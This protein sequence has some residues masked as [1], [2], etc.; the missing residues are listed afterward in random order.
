MEMGALE[1]VLKGS[2][3]GTL[4]APTSM[5][6]S[7]APSSSDIPPGSPVKAKSVLKKDNANWEE[8]LNKRR[9]YV[10]NRTYRIAHISTLQCPPW[11]EIPKGVGN[12]RVK[13]AG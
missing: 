12:E 1:Q 2:P 10:A 5:T 8:V 6:E 11:Y 7:T 3:N 13:H 4:S 9:D